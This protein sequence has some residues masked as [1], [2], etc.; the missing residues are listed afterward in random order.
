[1]KR[2][3]IKL[4]ITFIFEEFSISSIRCNYTATDNFHFHDNKLRLLDT[5]YGDT[6]LRQNIL[7]I[8]F[9]KHSF[10]LVSLH[11]RTNFSADC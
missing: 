11:N 6:Y 10:Y 4:K 3:Q 7:G 5:R 9:I 2:N 1:M 8:Y